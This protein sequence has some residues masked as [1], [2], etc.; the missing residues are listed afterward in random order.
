[1][2]QW[3][4]NPAPLTSGSVGCLSADPPKSLG[5]FWTPKKGAWLS[6]RD[7]NPLKPESDFLPHPSWPVPREGAKIHQLRHQL[8]GGREKDKST[9]CPET[10]Y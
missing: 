2:E 5:C 6:W 8:A 9:S 4:W 10:P 3:D 1:M 7:F